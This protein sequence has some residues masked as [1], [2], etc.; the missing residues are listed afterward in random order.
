ML[1]LDVAY[2]TQNMTT[3]SSAVPEI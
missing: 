3:L 1:G 2:F